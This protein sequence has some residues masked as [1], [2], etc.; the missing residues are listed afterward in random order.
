MSHVSSR[1]SPSPAA[2]FAGLPTGTGIGIIFAALFTG[3]LLSL[4]T[5][6]IGWPFLALYAIAVIVV[7]TLVNP[8]G[9]F[10]NVASA[11]LLFVAA[12][13]LAGWVMSR[14]EIAAGGAS[15]KAALLLVFYPVTELFPVLFAV[16]AGSVLIAVV[17]IR[18]IKR[19]NAQ[20]LRYE[21]AER[22]RVQQSNRRTNSEGRRA[23]ERAKAVPVQELLRRA[24]SE[25]NA[26]RSP[27]TGSSKITDRLG[28]DLYK[29]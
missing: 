3:V 10:L 5:A 17:R 7:A 23:R 29:G 26:K 11:P 21:T 18:L 16:T 13:I 20:L 6:A 28:E 27:R 8:K 2:T 1:N 24:D 9:L 12:V 4:S 14:A 25:R 19:H 15:G 22:T